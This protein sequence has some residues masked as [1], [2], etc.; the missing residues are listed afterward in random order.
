MNSQE[1]FQKA[2]VALKS[3]ELLLQ[4]GDFDGCCN[5]AYYAMFDAARAALLATEEEDQVVGIKTHSGL[6]SFFSLR[7]KPGACLW[8]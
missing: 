6:I 7:L 5:R 1:L 8:N 2:I 4:S 3:A